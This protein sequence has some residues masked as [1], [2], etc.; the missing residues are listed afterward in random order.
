MA[1]FIDQDGVEE[2]E[3]NSIENAIDSLNKAWRTEVHS[4]IILPYR[5]EL[6]DGV[7]GFLKKLANQQNIISDPEVFQ[8]EQYFTTT[9]YQMDIERTRY[10]V[11]RYLRTRLLKIE[12][13]LEYILTNDQALKDN[14]S[15]RELKFAIELYDIKT[16]HLD[17]IV[18]SL[19]DEDCRDYC[20]NEGQK[21]RDKNAKPQINEFVFYRILKPVKIETSPGNIEDLDF[22]DIGVVQYSA[23]KNYVELRDIELI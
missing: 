5:E 15:M 16:N 2:E 3:S 1:D 11:T 14:L 9:L 7:D 12:K 18:Y 22:G 10:S 4:P 17:S 21:C 6:I 8:E 13:N 19:L 20:K 23:I